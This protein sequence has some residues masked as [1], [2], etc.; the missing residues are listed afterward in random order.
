MLGYSCSGLLINQTLGDDFF[1]TVQTLNSN[2]VSTGE[3]CFWAAKIFNHLDDLCKAQTSSTFI[4]FSKY[5]FTTKS[6]LKWYNRKKRCACLQ[7][8]V[9]GTFAYKDADCK[10]QKR[11]VICQQCKFV[12]C[13]PRSVDCQ[14]LM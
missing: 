14:P 3:R 13:I 5:N 7:F 1:C 2:Y 8:T 9:L 10:K 6:V 12:V 4:G 11:T